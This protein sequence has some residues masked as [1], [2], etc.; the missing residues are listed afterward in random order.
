MAKSS[1][2]RCRAICIWVSSVTSFLILNSSLHLFEYLPNQSH[3]LAKIHSSAPQDATVLNIPLIGNLSTT[4]NDVNGVLADQVA[5]I[6]TN[7][8]P[9]LQCWRSDCPSPRRNHIFYR[10][11]HETG[12]NDRMTI[13]GHLANLAGYLGAN[14]HVYS[15]SFLLSPRHNNQE[16]VNAD[17]KWSDFLHLSFGYEQIIHEIN[18][19]SHVGP[20]S[21]SIR[22]T[23]ETP[24]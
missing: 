8:P 4:Q 7:P 16:P 9:T 19:S 10:N 12:W 1:R 20:D 23:S 22:V 14:L 13:F 18:E 15:P 21:K 24:E 2:N 6:P 11:L 3:H 5:Q 17:V